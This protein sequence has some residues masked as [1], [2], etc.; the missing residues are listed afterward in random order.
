VSNASLE[1]KQAPHRIGAWALQAVVASAFFAAGA[2]KLGAVPYMVLLFA[3]IGMGQWFRVVTGS[4]EIIGALALLHPRLAAIGGLWL[5]FTM[6]CA[7]AIHLAV[8]HTNPAPAVALG[9]L[10]A[11]IVYLRRDELA[12]I[13]R[14]VR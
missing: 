14:T 1:A 6:L 12:S 3:D 9:P 5:G 4:V 13:M 8:L 11:W 7:A 10:I 2:A